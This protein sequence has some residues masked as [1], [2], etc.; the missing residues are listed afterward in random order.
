MPSGS[1]EKGVASPSL[2][3]HQGRILRCPEARGVSPSA[4]ATL[5]ALAPF[6]RQSP[7]CP[8]RLPPNSQAHRG[9]SEPGAA[10]GPPWSPAAVFLPRAGLGDGDAHL[11]LLAAAPPRAPQVSRSLPGFRPAGRSHHAPSFTGLFTGSS[12]YAFLEEA[13]VF[14][15]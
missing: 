6:A 8:L 4:V 12:P 1:E 14:L 3:P 5:F 2:T 9:E 7:G 10:A 13:F 11:G 15:R